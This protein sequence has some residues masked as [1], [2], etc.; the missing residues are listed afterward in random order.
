MDL[1][2]LAKLRHLL[3]LME[4]EQRTCLSRFKAAL[5][6]PGGFY[7]ALSYS[8]ADFKAAARGLIATHIRAWIEVEEG[9]AK[10]D[11]RP[12]DEDAFMAVLKMEITKTIVLRAARLN[13]RTSSP[14]ADLM[15]EAITTA[16][17]ELL[18][19]L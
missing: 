11:G 8:G 18:E 4:I 3:D 12:L 2:G 17:A 10:E 15:E 14:Q 9:E 1:K 16:W 6:S 19:E 13:R 5:E 7:A